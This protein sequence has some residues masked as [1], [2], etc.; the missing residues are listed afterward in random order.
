MSVCVRLRLKFQQCKAVTTYKKY[1]LRRHTLLCLK[2]PEVLH[3][4]EHN[5]E[6]L[7]R[8]AKRLWQTRDQISSWPSLAK[9]PS[10]AEPRLFSAAGG[11]LRSRVSVIIR[12]TW[13]GT[14]ACYSRNANIHNSQHL[15]SA[16][17]V[18]CSQDLTST[19]PWNPPNEASAMISA[20]YRWQKEA[21]RAHVTRGKPFSWHVAE[22]GLEANKSSCRPGRVTPAVCFSQPA[23]RMRRQG[24]SPDLVQPE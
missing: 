6:T 9:L 1:W 17:L 4:G 5:R 12:I 22:P 15:L 14:G 13:V 7:H 23:A 2:C 24:R 16:D 10:T 11:H 3:C 8:R 18:K 21:P 20:F 19:N